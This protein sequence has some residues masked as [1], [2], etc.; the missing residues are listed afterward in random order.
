[1]RDVAMPAA[2]SRKKKILG[3]GLLIF[4]V[5]GCLIFLLC[6]FRAQYAEQSLLSRQRELEQAWVAKAVDAISVWRNELVEQ[7][8]FVSSSEMFR[9]F[10]M[11]TRQLAPG[12]LG[13][14][15][16]PDALHSEDEVLRSMAEQLN[17]MQDLL[18][19]FTR[20]RAWT[21]A[22]IL[23]PDASL[24]VGPDFS[25]PLDEAQKT[26]AMRCAAEGK[27]MF[28][29][30]RNTE[31][32]IVIDM[33]EPLFEVLGPG[34]PRAVA[35]LFLTAPMEK[36]L[37]SFL[38]HQGDSRATMWPRILDRGPNGLSMV[39]AEAGMTVLVALPPEIGHLPDYAFARRQ[40]LDGHG[41][42]YSMG[43]TPLGLD[44]RFVLEA[45][46]SD[47]D[48]AISDQKMQIYG[49]GALASIVLALLGAFVW[50]NATSK[51]HRA[52]VAELTRLNQQ[53]ERQR[54]MLKSINASMDAGL[55]LVDDHNDV[56]VCNPNFLRMLNISDIPEHTPLSQALAP[57]LALK[58]QGDMTRVKEEEKSASTEI[59]LENGAL[60]PAGDR[61]GERLGEGGNRLYRVTF[62]PYVENTG[63][64]ERRGAGCVAIFQDIT[65]FRIDSKIRAQREAA[66]LSALGRAI[67]SVDP[68]LVGHSDKMAELAG[69]LAKS[70][71]MD[72]RDAE[73]LRL[74]AL[75]SQVGKIFVP[76]ELLTRRGKLTPEEMAEV[77]KAPQHADRILHDLHFDLPVRETV[78]QIGER[79]DGSGSPDG[80][81]GYEI[82]LC[83]R[84]LAVI[85]AFIAMTSPRAWRGGDA[86]DTRQAIDIL[87]ADPRF[88]RDVVK[89]L[90]LIGTDAI[91]KAIFGQSGGEKAPR[92][93][94]KS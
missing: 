56:L 91:N 72:G 33:A 60:V 40:A 39:M 83:G 15:S 51:Q 37:T 30:L 84:A 66:V 36:P 7:A 25:L 76:N 77:Q 16:E 92:R 34:E 11:D 24:L 85:N 4:V 21:E 68:N 5:L 42:V 89:A 87:A 62:F 59:R 79:M 75:L 35:V 1:M 8:R 3:V 12:D 88:D 61:A 22:R 71:N 90:A 47:V 13:R 50:A 63:S 29:P 27:A 48:A 28:G 67:E 26:I 82:S 2:N 49:L 44:W 38:A 93:D 18:K 78:R 86:M 74:S 6:N 41:E 14:L 9:L 46:A 57:D 52:R 58:L 23:L 20:R 81:R 55:L 64:S 43:A 65:K 70:M 73:T 94:E 80:L 10:V 54:L 19:D 17:Y 53:I 45:P 32:G 69:L 31:K